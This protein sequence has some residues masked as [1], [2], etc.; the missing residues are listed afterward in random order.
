MNKAKRNFSDD[1][2]DYFIKDGKF[3]GEFEAMYQ[4]AAKVPW[5]QDRI[6]EIWHRRL[7]LDF[8]EC[9]FSEYSDIKSV[10]EIG[11]GYGY[12]LSA[13]KR[14]GIDFYGCD[15]SSTAI[16]KARK[17]EKDCRFFVDDITSSQNRPSYS[18]VIFFEVIW[19]IL[20]EFDFVLENLKKIAN[21]YLSLSIT[22]PSNKKAFY[23]KD[24]FPD[25]ESL[26]KILEKDFDTFS[27][28]RLQKSEDRYPDSVINFYWL[29]CKK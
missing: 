14:K 9:A 24:T 21:P 1:Y 18:L 2:H 10:L 17:R 28:M 29:G 19:C 13:I 26:L 27:T 11:C 8:L 16:A 22:F 25:P 3:I 20:H 23:G 7:G 12:L 5:Q 15:V 4:N 6:A